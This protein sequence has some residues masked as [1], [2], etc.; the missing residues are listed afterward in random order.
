MKNLDYINTLVVEMPNKRTLQQSTCI[1]SRS[2]KKPQRKSR[3]C[4]G[5]YATTYILVVLI[6]TRNKNIFSPEIDIYNEGC[7]PAQPYVDGYDHE[8]PTLTSKDKDHTPIRTR[9]GI[10]CGI[11]NR[12]KE[13]HVQRRHKHEYAVQYFC[14]G[15]HQF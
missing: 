15:Y 7:I 10:H 8:Y 5:C 6:E 1:Y 13:K 12:R 14:L 9:V 3:C 4:T 11:G 2:P